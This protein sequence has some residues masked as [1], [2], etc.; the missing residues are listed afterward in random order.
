MVFLVGWDVGLHHVE[1]HFC[2]G[3]LLMWQKVEMMLMYVYVEGQIVETNLEYSWACL[4]QH[5]A[6]CY[7]TQC[8]ICNVVCLTSPLRPCKIVIIL[9]LNEE[10]HLCWSIWCQNHQCRGRTQY[11]VWYVSI[12]LMYVEWVYNYVVQDCVWESYKLKEL[13][14]LVHTCLFWFCNISSCLLFLYEDDIF[15]WYL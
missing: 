7:S 14:V 5:I 9:W 12:N 13:L 2:K 6:F 15:P 3:W 4:S 8:S 1:W 11:H 10:H